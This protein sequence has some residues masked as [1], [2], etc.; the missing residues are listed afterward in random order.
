M[1]NRFLIQFFFKTGEASWPAQ[2]TF[3]PPFHR[4]NVIITPVNDNSVMDKAV[5]ILLNRVTEVAKATNSG[6]DYF[7]DYKWYEY[8]VKK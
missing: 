3:Q 8:W 2:A 7:K 6:K 5:T 4:V 1:E